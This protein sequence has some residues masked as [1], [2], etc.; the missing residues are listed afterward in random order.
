MTRPS[1]SYFTGPT[2]GESPASRYCRPSLRTNHLRMSFDE[3]GGRHLS[4]VQF[5]MKQAALADQPDVPMA[6]FDDTVEPSN[7]WPPLWM[8]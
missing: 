3:F 2:I 6:I 5:Q 8:R 4:W 7:R 1:R